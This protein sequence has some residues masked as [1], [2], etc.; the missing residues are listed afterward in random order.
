MKTA[1]PIDD[2]TGEVFKVVVTNESGE[3]L[4]ETTRNIV[5]LVATDH[6]GPDHGGALLTAGVDEK[7][8][9]VLAGAALDNLLRPLTEISGEV[10]VERFR[11]GVIHGLTAALSTDMGRMEVLEKERASTESAPAPSPS[12]KT[13]SA[14]DGNAQG[15]GD[16]AEIA[17][18]A[19]RYSLLA[20]IFESGA[21]LLCKDLG[22]QDAND[23]SDDT[24]QPDSAC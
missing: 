5:L 19:K 20:S 11:M 15:P 24:S 22:N 12:E 21:D 10:D 17:S 4:F 6:G 2:P 16:A 1:R 3:V 7:D 18:K 8:L 13:N 9:A 14:S 23:E